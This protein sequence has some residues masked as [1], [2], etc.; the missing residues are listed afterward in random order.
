M[1]VLN[2]GWKILRFHATTKGI[3]FF[4]KLTDLY[5]VLVEDINEN[6]VFTYSS[7]DRTLASQNYKNMKQKLFRGDLDEDIY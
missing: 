2:S 3:I 5:C 1:D 7:F 4:L 6:P